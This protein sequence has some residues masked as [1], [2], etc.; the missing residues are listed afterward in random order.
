LARSVEVTLPV[1]GW[2]A[3]GA[4]ILFGLL[5]LFRTARSELGRSRNR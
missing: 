2:F 5:G 1:V 3:A 4:L